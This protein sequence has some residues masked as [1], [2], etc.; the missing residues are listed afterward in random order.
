MSIHYIQGKALFM[1]PFFRDMG[2][3]L[4][5]GSDHRL[6]IESSEGV[7]NGLIVL[8]FNNRDDASGYLEEQGIPVDGLFANLIKRDKE[9]GILYKVTRKHMM[10]EFDEPYMG[11]PQVVDAN[12]QPWDKNVLIGNGS[13]VTV[14]LNV[15]I[16]RKKREIR[17][18]G[19][20]VDNLVEYVKEE[21]P[22]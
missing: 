19:M 20:R 5:E 2:E 14:K 13:D 11:P 7:Y 9:H 10:K 15:W 12:A 22:F 8:P 18:E 21:V 1:R 6:K 3:N 17:W 4:P 16:G